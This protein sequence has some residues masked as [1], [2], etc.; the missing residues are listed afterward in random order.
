MHIVIGLISAVAGLLFALAALERAGVRLSSLNPFAWYRRASWK[1]KYG[2]GPLSGLT[3]PLDVVSVLLVGIAKCEGDLSAAQKNRIREILQTEFALT[4]D[5]ADDQLV[6]ATFMTKDQVYLVDK[7]D[8][9][10]AHVKS[11]ADA[12]QKRLLVDLMHR[13]AAVD[14]AVNFE[15]Q[16]LLDETRR[17][18]QR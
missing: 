5:R 17:L 6:A 18:L 13:V 16:R 12:R 11:H 10:L 14:G 9:V 2:A 7:L 8:T 3:D 4:A 15:Q 1:S